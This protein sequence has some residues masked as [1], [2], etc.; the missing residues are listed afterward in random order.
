MRFD[1]R[2]NC[3][4]PFGMEVVAFDVEALHLGVTHLD[5]LLVRPRVESTLDF[6]SG[7]G[8]R[9]ADQLNDGKTISQRTASP[10]LGDVA[11]HAVNHGVPR[12]E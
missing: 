6:Q 4:V 9:R 7:L 12:F 3:V 8:C 2:L 5:T 10:V 1:P 11:K